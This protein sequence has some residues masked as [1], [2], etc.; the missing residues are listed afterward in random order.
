M[1]L[2]LQYFSSN[3]INLTFPLMIILIVHFLLSIGSHI[4]MK[5]NTLFSIAYMNWPV[6]IIKQD[7]IK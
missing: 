1:V 4:A 6:V 3:K 5:S 2:Y 7:A